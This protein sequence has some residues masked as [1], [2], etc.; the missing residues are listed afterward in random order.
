MLR[1]VRLMPAVSPT[2]IGSAPGSILRTSYGPIA[3]SAVIP[4]KMSIATF[5]IPP[6]LLFC[7]S[8]NAA[9][10][11][12][13]RAGRHFERADKRAAHRFAGAEAA[14]GRDRIDAVLRLLEPAARRF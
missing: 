6:S 14:F 10:A 7:I 8:S 9:E 3:S 5:M 1:S 12:P 2:N 11:A 13:V 4:S